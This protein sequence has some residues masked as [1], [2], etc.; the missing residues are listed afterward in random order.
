M[1]LTLNII[2][3][4]LDK[5]WK[6]LESEQKEAQTEFSKSASYHRAIQSERQIAGVAKLPHVINF[7]KNIMEIE[8]SVVVF[9]HHKVIHKLLHE[10]LTRIFTCFYYWWAI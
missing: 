3:K 7:V 2:L 10:S 6:K 5:I 8:E 1:H 9:C 4:S